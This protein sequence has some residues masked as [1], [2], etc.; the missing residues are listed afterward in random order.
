MYFKCSLMHNGWLISYP[1]GF[2][3]VGMRPLIKIKKDL[4]KDICFLIPSMN[5][6]GVEKVT[7]LLANALCERGWMVT[8]LMTNREGPFLHRLNRNISIIELKYEAI[9]KN[10]FQIASYLKST[11]PGIFYASMMYVNVIALLASRLAGFKGRLFISEHTHY[12]SSTASHKSIK[13]WIMLQL[14]KRLY[15]NA[16]AVVCVS[17]AVKDNTTAL[18]K[19]IKKS[20]VIYNPVENLPDSGF[21]RTNIKYRIISMGRLHR[22]KNFKLLIQ[23]FAEVLLEIENRE[24]YELYILGEGEERSNLEKQ[25][26][27][28]GLNRQVFL[29]GFMASP[30]KMLQSSDLFVFTSITEGFGNV[31]VEALTCGLPVISSDCESGPSEILL[32]G[33]IGVLVPINDK[34]KLKNAILEEITK[35]NHSSTRAQRMARA[36]DFLIDKIILQYQ[37]LFENSF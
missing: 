25:I 37:Q 12:S 35:P 27:T 5:G 11:K 29:P 22:D 24:S 26:N 21:I 15:K 20:V 3:R 33:K 14:A 8:L 10:I 18:I 34:T 7:L 6:G 31:L 32:A 36:N 17:Q 4:K 2:S 13:S 23:C 16:T 30:A 28:L 9:S 1:N 19:N